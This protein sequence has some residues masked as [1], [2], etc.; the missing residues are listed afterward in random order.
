[1]TREGIEAR[2]E[3]AID[4]PGEQASMVAEVHRG[5]VVFTMWTSN[6]QYGGA[7]GAG[8]LTFAELLAQG[9]PYATD[10]PHWPETLDHLKSHY[11]DDGFDWSEVIYYRIEP[12]WMVAYAADPASIT[13]ATASISTS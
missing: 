4:S 13:A 2:F 11:G 9:P 7:A 10:D 5:G 1:M 6:P 12:T 3:W 8:A